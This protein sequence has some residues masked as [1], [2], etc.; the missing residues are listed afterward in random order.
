MSVHVVL[1]TNVRISAIIFKGKPL[2]LVR[3][4]QPPAFQQ[5]VSTTLLNEL[6]AVLIGKFRWR[7]SAA[8]REVA[9]VS[10]QCFLVEAQ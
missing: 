9:L 4:L 6:L 7:E 10:E 8:K 1:D 2:D 3:R 5:V